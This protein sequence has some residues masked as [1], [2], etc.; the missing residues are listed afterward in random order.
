MPQVLCSI[1]M[2]CSALYCLVEKYRLLDSLLPPGEQ[3]AV[4]EQVEV[5]RFGGELEL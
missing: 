4:V 1:H 2:Y 5:H 3:E